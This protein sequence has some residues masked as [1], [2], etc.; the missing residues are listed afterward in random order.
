MARDFAAA[1]VQTSP[2]H[3]HLFDITFY[4]GQVYGDS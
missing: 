1:F 2:E 4:V 3:N